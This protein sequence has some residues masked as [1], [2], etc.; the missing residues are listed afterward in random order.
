[1]KRDA[2]D[3]FSVRAG[4]EAIHDRLTNWALW[5]RGG[6]GGSS[7]LPM[8]RFYR[9]DGYHELTASIPVD[10][11]DATR[12]QK[13]MV[14]LPEKHRWAIQWGYV[15]SFIPVWKVQRELGVTRTGLYDLIHDARSMLKNRGGVN[16]EAN[17]RTSP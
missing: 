2:V 3:F 8:F 12:L 13:L 15:F 7:T 10:S 17:A 9:P 14:V 4:H 11:L 6:R 1:M 16:V 5:S